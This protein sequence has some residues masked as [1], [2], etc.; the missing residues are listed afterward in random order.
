MVS[1]FFFRRDVKLTITLLNCS[2]TSSVFTVEVKFRLHRQHEFSF[3]FVS[4]KHDRILTKF[5]ISMW[6]RI[7]PKQRITVV[8]C[9]KLITI[10]GNQVDVFR[11]SIIDGFPAVKM[12]NYWKS[13]S[14]FQWIDHVI[15][16]SLQRWPTR[17]KILSVQVD[18]HHC[19]RLSKAS[20]LWNNDFKCI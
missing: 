7:F 13:I 16:I 4:F 5:M 10:S 9:L 19:N 8:H 20:S 1:K 14:L 3:T 11:F 17:L 18:F 12:Q 2:M 6:V 15:G